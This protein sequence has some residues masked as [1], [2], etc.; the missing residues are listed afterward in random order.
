MAM[1]AAQLARTVADTIWRTDTCSQ[2]LGM[3]LEAVRP[4]YA[5]IR[6][7][8]RP[9]FLNGHGICHGGMLFT[10]ADTT[11]AFAANSRNAPAVTTGGSIEY[12][13][14]V[15]GGDVLTA[16]GE[17]QTL[18]GRHGIY[19]IRVRNAAG[20]TVAMFR[21]RAAQRPGTILG[22]A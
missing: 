17:E 15:R 8:V 4:G 3:Q 16:E 18:T 22:S 7:P 19:D 12:L 6:M 20:E 1:D 11:F 13:K 2:W 9:E 10:L 14:P 21:G 5:R